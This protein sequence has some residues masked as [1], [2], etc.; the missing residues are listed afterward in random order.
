MSSPTILLGVEILYKNFDVAMFMSFSVDV[1]IIMPLVELWGDDVTV[2][3]LSQQVIN[4][5]E[6]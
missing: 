4:L 3:E 6:F 5:C 1:L 2:I